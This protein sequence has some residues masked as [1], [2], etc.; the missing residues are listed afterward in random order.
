MSDVTIDEELGIATG[1][2][3]STREGTKT[4]YEADAVIFAVGIT[5]EF[6]CLVSANGSVGHVCDKSWRI[7]PSICAKLVDARWSKWQL[8][9]VSVKVRLE[10]VMEY[11]VV[12]LLAKTSVSRCTIERGFHYY[13]Q[14][15]LPFKCAIEVCH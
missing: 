5:G 2:T 3:A 14:Y 8:H 6:G 15:F 12:R 13:H 7:A 11:I 4:Y 9:F 1:V 10:T